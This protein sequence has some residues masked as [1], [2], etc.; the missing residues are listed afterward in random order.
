MPRRCA[1]TPTHYQN[2]VDFAEIKKV[3]FEDP[4]ADKNL[5]VIAFMEEV[6]PKDMGNENL[7]S[8]KCQNYYYFLSF[9]FNRIPMQS[10]RS[11][12]FL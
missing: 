12:I 8:G 10:S 9:Q 7:N 6:K 2:S 4:Y 3:Q 1:A 11:V 5:S